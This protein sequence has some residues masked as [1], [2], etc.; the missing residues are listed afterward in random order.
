MIAYLRIL[1]NP[2]E[3]EAM[4]RIINYPVRGI[5]ATTINKISLA[6]QEENKTFWDILQ[7]PAALGFKGAT[8]TALEN[9]VVMIRNFQA[10]LEKKNA[11]EVAFEIGKASGLVNDLYTDKTV[12]GL[13]RYE[14]VQELLNSIKEYTET[15]TEDGELV[16]KNLGSYLQQITLLT[17]ADKDGEENQDVVKLMTIHASKGLEFPCVFLVGM[18]ENIFPSS[19]SMYDRDD[20]EEER[21]LFYVA[22]TRAKEKLWISFATNRYRFGSLV[23]ND[24]SRFL[25]ELPKPLVDDSLASKPSKRTIFTKPSAEKDDA[26]QQKK[27]P[28]STKATNHIASPNFQA[29]DPKKMTAGMKVEHERFGFGNIVSMEGPIANKIAT[30]DFG[31]MGQKKIMLNYAKLRIVQ[32]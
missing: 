2:Q 3:E 14:N 15:P 5:G 19:M 17:D 29:D 31:T 28:T 4:R 6:A 32:S 13:A 27:I 7:T 25:D 21:R 8:L 23:Q 22:I 20:L 18:E 26:I 11:Y 16:E 24:P 12:E 9:F 1:V 30:I 10:M